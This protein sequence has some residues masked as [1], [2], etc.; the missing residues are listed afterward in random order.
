M[1]KKAARVSK[2]QQ[3]NI[4]ARAILQ[5]SIENKSIIEDSWKGFAAK[6][7]PSVGPESI[8]YIEMRK[9]YFCGFYA[10]FDFMAVVSDAFTEDE[11]MDILSSAK[12]Q[13]ETEIKK[14]AKWESL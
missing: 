7:I 9:A 2:R 11:A 3:F 6:V 4:K 5:R 1:W 12:E 10:N 13:A 14:F 8:Q